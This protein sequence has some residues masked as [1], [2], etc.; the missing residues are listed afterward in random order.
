MEVYLMYLYILQL[1]S[2]Y[3]YSVKDNV[4]SDRHL[5]NL[6]TLEIVCY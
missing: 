4:I 1:I 3:L 6:W 5:E 2:L